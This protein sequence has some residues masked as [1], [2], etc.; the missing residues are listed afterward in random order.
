MGAV[1]NTWLVLS[2]CQS[3]GRGS[4]KRRASGGSHC[5][6]NERNPYRTGVAREPVSSST[7]NLDGERV[8]RPSLTYLPMWRPANSPPRS[9][10]WNSLSFADLSGSCLS[11]SHL[12]RSDIASG[13]TA[14]VLPGMTPGPTSSIT[15]SRGAKS[16]QPPAS[17]GRNGARQSDAPSAQPFSASVTVFSSSNFASRLPLAS[18]R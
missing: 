3:R 9:C 16:A 4:F 7:F 14:Q 11:T 2:E 17:S 8:P 10:G 6:S 18:E 13:A 15:E 1:K 12:R 5:L